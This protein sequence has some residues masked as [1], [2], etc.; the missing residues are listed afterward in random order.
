MEANRAFSLETT[1]MALLQT[2]PKQSGIDSRQWNGDVTVGDYDLDGYP[3]VY[4][5]NMF[6]ENNLFRNNGNG[7]FSKVTRKV[8]GRT[9]WGGI[10]VLFFDATNDGYPEL[11]VVDVHSDVAGPITTQPARSIQK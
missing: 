1:G 2:S 7:T 6:G 11:Y 9:S 10:G 5:S 3:D 4:T 8:L